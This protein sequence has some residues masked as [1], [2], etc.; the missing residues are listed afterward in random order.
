MKSPIAIQISVANVGSLI[1]PEELYDF[2]ERNTADVKSYYLDASRAKGHVLAAIE[3][4]MILSAVGSVAS[5]ASL[6]WMAYDKFIAEKKRNPDDTAG[7][8]IAIEHPDGTLYQFWLGNEYKDRELF[9]EEFTEKMESLRDDER[10]AEF[11]HQKIQEL[12]ALDL[13]VRRK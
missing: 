1:K 5:I 7:L 10:V 4:V 13:I 3:Y 12:E 6:L 11:T 9:I 8:Y 2:I